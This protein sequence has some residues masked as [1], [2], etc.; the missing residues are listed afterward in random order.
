MGTTDSFEVVLVEH[1]GVVFP[2][3]VSVHIVR[4]EELSRGR[5]RQVVDSVLGLHDFAAK[6]ANVLL[7]IGLC[8]AFL[9]TLWDACIVAQI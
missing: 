8:E 5:V 4:A 7:H 2:Q 3:A 6:F 1:A 9:L